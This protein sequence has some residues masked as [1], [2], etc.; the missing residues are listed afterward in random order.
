MMRR[1]DASA[2]DS[3]ARSLAHPPTHRP[4][5]PSVGPSKPLGPRL[6]A[7]PLEPACE[8][9]P[10][11][12]FNTVVSRGALPLIFVAP[13]CHTSPYSPALLSLLSPL[14]LSYSCVFIFVDSA[15]SNS[16]SHSLPS[17][18]RPPHA[19]DAASLHP[20]QTQESGPRLSRQG[21]FVPD[22]LDQQHLPTGTSY[23]C[24]P[25]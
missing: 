20:Q 24:M 10:A 5:Y 4:T 23:L 19:A 15:R 22:S 8:A 3:L 6:A 7:G 1:E 14:L 9:E 18:E 17:G 2:N 25:S 16:L 13:F 11:P 12:Q 21:H